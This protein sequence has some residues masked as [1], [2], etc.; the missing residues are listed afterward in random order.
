M[1]DLAAYLARI[2]IGRRPDLP[3]LH[4]A[5]TA[6]IPFENL[7]PRRGV[8]VSLELEDLERKLVADR[9]GGY[10]F[11]QNLLLKAALEALGV[12][13]VELFL[14]R[15]RVGAAPGDPRPRTHLLLGV[16]VDGTRWHADVGFGHGTLLEPIP[17]GPGDEHE[18]SGWRYRVVEE[19][20]ELVLQSIAQSGEWADLY[21]FVPEPVP[22]IDV[23]TSN[24]FTCTHPRSPF[25]TGLIVSAQRPD[26]ARE[27]LSNWSGEL[28]LTEETPDAA[29]VTRV[30]PD[31]VP[32]LVATRFG[33][34]ATL[35]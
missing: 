13:N 28:T 26:G 7:D 2:G 24:W 6:T 31:A 25:V 16:Q 29:T 18:Q 33:L 3:E 27:S 17:F 23:V 11:E 34:E 12:A 32:E 10:C 20:P 21:G 5:H 14:A 15:V 30:D 9:R 8:P 4:R 22:L 35:V 1:L 19:G